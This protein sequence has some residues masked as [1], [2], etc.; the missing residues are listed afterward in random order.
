MTQFG[1]NHRFTTFDTL[2]FGYYCNTMFR[3]FEM[4]HGV[5]NSI[6]YEDGVGKKINRIVGT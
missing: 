2:N 4:F 1:R 5:T 3:Y 6:P